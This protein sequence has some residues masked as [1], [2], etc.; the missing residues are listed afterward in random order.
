MTE[1]QLVEPG[2]GILLVV[3]GTVP[4]STHANDFTKVTIRPEHPKPVVNSG[5]ASLL[6]SWDWTGFD[7]EVNTYNIANAKVEVIFTSKFKNGV[8]IDLADGSYWMR[9]PDGWQ[10]MYVGDGVNSGS[11]HGR[12]A[13]KQPQR[14][15]EAR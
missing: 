11:I 5:S 6:R 2:D 8:H 1:K 10:P 7:D 3:K 14:L 4:I 12:N 13:P 15:K 9:R